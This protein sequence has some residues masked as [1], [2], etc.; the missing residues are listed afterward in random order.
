MLRF[1]FEV[2]ESV[3][4]VATP[5]W[6]VT[7]EAPDVHV[8]E[9]LLLDWLDWC[10]ADVPAV[11]RYIGCTTAGPGGLRPYPWDPGQHPAAETSGAL[12]PH[13]DD[14]V[15]DAPD[16]G[17]EAHVETFDLAPDTKPPASAFASVAAALDALRAMYG[18][19]GMVYSATVMEERLLVARCER[20]AWMLDP[21]YLHSL[22]DRLDATERGV[23]RLL[24]ERIIQRAMETACD[25]T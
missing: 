5:A 11:H 7:V 1:I 18:R 24:R 2:M 10:L 22:T 25:L 19:L 4:G 14:I 21:R 15:T 20:P 16:T 8:A 13:P 6:R 23:S 17:R 9:L 12:V 3:A